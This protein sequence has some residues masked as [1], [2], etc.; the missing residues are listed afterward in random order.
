MAEGNAGVFS[1]W[2][3]IFE[4]VLTLH[5]SELKKRRNAKGSETEIGGPVLDLDELQKNRVV[6]TNYETVRRYQHSFAYK[7]GGKSLWSVMVTDEAQE[8]KDPASNISWAIKAVEPD[9]H[10]ASTGTPVENRLLDLWNLFDAL[11]SGHLGSEK[12]YCSKYETPREEPGAAGAALEDLRG[13][14]RFGKR[15][16]YLIRREKTSLPGFPRKEEHVL[17][18]SMSEEEIEQHNELKRAMRSGHMQGDHLRVLHRFRKLYQHPALLRPEGV[19]GLTPE[20]L[21]ESSVK[22]REVVG[23]LRLIQRKK[24]KAIVFAY[25]HAVQAI[26]CQVLEAEFRLPVKVVNGVTQKSSTKNSY[27]SG[28]ARETRAGI[29]KE[30]QE[31]NGFHVLVLSPFVAGVGLTITEA[32]HV[33]HYGRWWNP[34]TE[35]QAT[36]R[37]YRI[38]QTRDVHV[39]WPILRD[40]SGRVPIS[41]DQLLDDLLRRRRDLAR[42]FLH[43]MPAD[44]AN[45]DVL[46]EGLAGGVESGEARVLTIDE[47]DRMK[48]D[49]F[50]ALAACWYESAGFRTVLTAQGGDSGA[51]VVAF[52]G[53]AV[54]LVQVKHSAVGAAIGPEALDD[55]EGARVTYGGRLDC[56]PRLAI[57]TN[58]AVS[59]QLL[60]RAEESG[61][62]LIGRKTLRDWVAARPVSLTDV[63]KRASGRCRSFEQGVREARE[64]KVGRARNDGD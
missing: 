26:L 38:G 29:L 22:L 44:D 52:D 7:R 3:S 64:L 42:D 43:P 62:E 41:F 48:A 47:V 24:E 37:A 57:V 54:T 10:I 12:D 19:E 5:G 46:C 36:D 28:R 50:E 61:V 59:N 18:C 60:R 25:D 34:A 51:D 63:W 49:D 39:Y 40:T 31:R 30:F 58:G 53:R 35:S 45:A 16:A 20:S 32:N 33:V 6:L 55:L 23:Q 9:F 56:H 27:W 4:P 13:R 14:L 17:D 21:L 1:A 2:G 15:D 11:Q 8:Y